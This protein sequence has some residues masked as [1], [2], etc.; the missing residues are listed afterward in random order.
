MIAKGFYIM[1][2]SW[3]LL[4]IFIGIAKV[5]FDYVTSRKQDTK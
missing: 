5:I 2:G 1:V 3:A 4:G